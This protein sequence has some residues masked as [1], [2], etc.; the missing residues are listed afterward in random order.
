[1][2]AI[3]DLRR[4]V[5]PVKSREK[6]IARQL[7]VLARDNPGVY[8][9]LKAVDNIKPEG[10]KLVAYVQELN[11]KNIDA[12][13]ARVINDIARKEVYKATANQPG[14]DNFVQ[15]TRNS[16]TTKAKAKEI[17]EKAAASEI[18]KLSQALKTATPKLMEVPV[19]TRAFATDVAETTKLAPVVDLTKEQSLVVARTL[20]QLVGLKIF[21]ADTAKTIIELVRTDK[22]ITLRD[23]RKILDAEID[24]IAEAQPTIIRAR[25]I[26]LLS[27]PQKTERLLQPIETKH[28]GADLFVDFVTKFFRDIKGQVDQIVSPAQRTILQ[29]AL[30]KSGNLDVAL[31]N[32]MAKALNDPDFRKAYGMPV[33]SQPTR[34]NALAYLV[35]GPEVGKSSKNIKSV[36]EST[37][38]SL[39]FETNT[40]E[41]IFDQ[42]TGAKSFRDNSI[43]NGSGIQQ[44]DSV[45]ETATANILQNPSNLWEE[46]MQVVEF[47]ENLSKDPTYLKTAIEPSKVTRITEDIARKTG[48][49]SLPPEVQVGAFYRAEMDRIAKES[50]QE[51]VSGTAKTTTPNIEQSI[52]D[53][54]KVILKNIADAEATRLRELGTDLLLEQGAVAKLKGTLAEQAAK[55][56]VLRQES[57]TLGQTIKEERKELN[58]SAKQKREEI[59][60]L[61]DEEDARLKLLGQKEERL[62]LKTQSKAEKQKIKE[63]V[64]KIRQGLK[65]TFAD[66]RAEV[67][68]GITQRKE[69]REAIKTA[70]ES[71]LSTKYKIKQEDISRM[72]KV[73]AGENIKADLIG[74]LVTSRLAKNVSGEDIGK[75]SEMSIQ[76]I[77][78]DLPDSWKTPT[79]I[80]KDELMEII[81]SADEVAKT[82]QIANKISTSGSVDDISS[83]I[84]RYFQDP[85]LEEQARL[86]FGS[87][88]YKQINENIGQ[89]G[90]RLNKALEDFVAKEYGPNQHIVKKTLS[91]LNDVIQE[92]F[93]TFTL[94]LAPRFHFGNILGAPGILYKTLGATGIRSLNKLGTATKLIADSVFPNKNLSKIIVTDNAGRSYTAGEVY[95]MISEIGT[96]SQFSRGTQ[97]VAKDMVNVI[98]DTALSKGS[99]YATNIQ[100]MAEAEDKTFR[101]AVLLKALEDGRGA[102]EAIKLARASLYDLGDVGKIV[103][104]EKIANQYLLFYNFTRNNLINTVELLTSAQGLSRIAKYYRFTRGIEG[105]PIGGK[106]SISTKEKAMMSEYA[107][108]RII[109]DTLDI[110]KDKYAIA[111]APDAMLDGLNLL[112]AIAEG[113]IMDK[114]F[115]MVRPIFKEKE[116]EEPTKIDPEFVAAMNLF[117]DATRNGIL[118]M[119]SG[120]KDINPQMIEGEGKKIETVYPLDTPSQRSHYD[121]I[122]NAL[123]WVGISR[124]ISDFGKTFAVEGSATDRT[125]RG[126][127]GLAAYT[128]AIATP[129]KIANAERVALYNTLN[130]TAEGK[131]FIKDIEKLAQQPVKI[132]SEEESNIVKLRSL[133]QKEKAE[134]RPKPK[135]EQYDAA[136]NYDRHLDRLYRN[137]KISK[138]QMKTMAKA[139]KNNG[140]VEP[141]SNVEIAGVKYQE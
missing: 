41:A 134:Q 59:A 69:T 74:D 37:V 111:F 20:Q 78:R 44:I 63:E 12:L 57:K 113:Q 67:G 61:I 103:K 93:Y 95:Q 124:I 15:L 110:G 130:Q 119:L 48:K 80:T 101:T 39:I 140:F 83:Q 135:Q 97:N 116:E 104:A 115:G 54:A 118:T 68:A 72:E 22:V 84:A 42:V 123:N 45:I 7:G 106:E 40:K 117:P 96:Q 122:K 128:T 8:D 112:G 36:L 77:I 25:D 85:K 87:D 120:S 107:Q 92:I 58:L 70:T 141:Q 109:L 136:D 13:K 29:Q 6:D 23:L 75:Y 82:I 17:L 71:L 137:G 21:P 47:A 46:M 127:L 126:L 32:S 28:F 73:I 138:G 38:Q 27:D 5:I 131:K 10:S 11:T 31:R 81:V 35:V 108:S 129:L 105:T 121:F 55:G 51:V 91:S 33:D 9:V 100:R 1:M 102:D 18:G 50:L 99:R 89:G 114:I 52:S 65:K 43:F 90:S 86:L 24:L 16:F 132:A 62:L 133:K 88:I 4:G 19:E 125:D 26:N 76:D 56:K 14:F 2:E 66:K 64:S 49:K 53:S 139:F 3:D 98:T 79:T 94:T 34:Q 30:Q 60:T